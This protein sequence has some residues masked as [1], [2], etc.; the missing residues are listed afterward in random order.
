MACAASFASII[1]LLD[2]FTSSGAMFR[3]FSRRSTRNRWIRASVLLFLLVS[4]I[5]LFS[6]SSYRSAAAR[7]TQTSSLIPSIASDKIF[8]ASIHWNN[9]A[10]LSSNWTS[11]LISLTKKLG[12]ENVYVSILESGSWDESKAVLKELDDALEELKVSKRVILSSSTHKDEMEK[13]I[14][15]G[16]IDTSR[17]RKELRR[18]PYL[19]RLRN[20]A[21]KPLAE[22]T[23]KGQSY[24][25]IVWIND[26]V[27]TPEDVIELLNTRD[28]DY[29][30][31]CS[32]DFAKP[33]EYYDTFALRDL[34]GDEAATSTF[35]YFRSR[36]SREAMLRGMP[37]PVQSCWNGIVAFDAEPWTGID[38][39]EFRG[40]HDSLAAYHLE[41]SECCLVHADNP[42][43]TS[44][45]VWLNPNVRVGY[46]AKAY[47]A[48][49][50]SEP[51]PNTTAVV[52]G[53]WRNR[54]ARLFT[55]TR[56][57]QEF[58]NKKLEQWASRDKSR[59]EPGKVC[60]INEMQV[61]AE[62]GWAHV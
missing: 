12:P 13:P 34:N 10:V 62:N 58:T 29:A 45:G 11:S 31:A 38:K 40:I 4:L 32:L 59:F 49:H 50:K 27:F 44:R 46:N 7:H 41:G 3:P 61:L 43:T 37:V 8:L 56:L 23:D 60:L 18:I 15:E 51:W 54:I 6:L 42:L 35:P 33:P 1:G 36:S 17:G 19:S 22:E 16:W 57:K 21:M 20:E 39:V 9:A 25:R 55:T 30:A 47:E 48:V 5:D 52:W 14:G 26:V 24:G 53:S 28:G 2:A